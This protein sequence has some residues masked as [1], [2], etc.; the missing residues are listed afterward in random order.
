MSDSVSRLKELLFD[1]ERATLADLRRRIEIVA[2]AERK[3]GQEL[4]ERIRQ[5]GETAAKGRTELGARIE[6]VFERA[7]TE[8]RFRGS[9]A[10][11]LDGAL[12]EA[13]VQRHDE[14][15]RAIAPLVV[16]TIKTELANS[17]DDMVQ[18]LY[19]IT[20]RLVKAYVASAIKDLMDDINRKLEAGIAQNRLLL[21]LR[22][23]TTGRS[24]AELALA[25][26][27]KPAVT[28]A[29]LIK[30]G[31]GELVQRWP[32]SVVQSNTDI[33]LSGVLS[34]I[35]DFA[36]QAFKNDGGG[37]R[38]FEMDNAE[39]FLRAS[40]IY[41]LAVKV[42]GPELP[43]SETLMDEAFLTTM[44]RH[45]S[46]LAAPPSGAADA[47]TS[48]AVLE[49]LAHE[50]DAKLGE[51]HGRYANAGGGTKPLA[52]IAAALAV[53]L[54]ALTGWWLYGEIETARAR[55]A[56][57]QVVNSAASL[58]L[59]RP[60]V[61]V[62]RWGRTIT[63]T[64]LA[65]NEAVKSEVM[66]RLR[67]AL[68]G[69]QIEDRISV[70][71]NVLR[72]VEPQIATVRRDVN[73]LEGEITRATMARAVDRSLRRL[74]IAESD[75]ARLGSTADTEERRAIVREVRAALSQAIREIRLY[76]GV[77]AEARGDGGTLQQLS[78][79]LHAATR[80]LAEATIEMGGYLTGARPARTPSPATTA[81]SDPV[82]SAEDLAGAAER[83]ATRVLAVLEATQVRP[84]P[85]A[86]RVQE[87]SA[88]DRLAAFTKTDAVFF[89]NTV[90]YRTP[91]A[92]E[93]TLDKLKALMAETTTLVRVVG[94]TDE[95]GGTNRNTPL[96][97]SRA[98][99]V[100]A[101]LVARGVPGDRLVAVGR[102][103]GPDISPS[104]GVGSP[105][106]R[107]EFEIGFAGEAGSPR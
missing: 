35:N 10:T 66:D 37:V 86:V 38:S 30:R 51:R 63:V 59:Y 27:Q 75:L 100:V 29:F 39:V 53:P 89:A 57:N 43:G 106:R 67:Q 87:P 96:S 34:A 8:E 64:A 97:Q 49:T 76:Q 68:P 32:T 69:T 107:V 102:A 21:R 90:D 56:A 16:R 47:R 28:D 83:M 13:E 104:T 54:I 48:G 62:E 93:A 58:K 46:T 4:G 60:D 101:D 81:P 92:A 91:E 70:I 7:G 95:R 3:T 61:D 72:E 6:Q 85:V 1:G 80:R 98:D 45:R 94:Y 42:K 105:N 79:S 55:S 11:V 78:A 25:A 2:E 18:A 71:P 73:T 99:K 41:L 65:P 19:P 31:S 12:R 9:V 23:I 22:S 33:H 44:E 26:T 40:P 103:L 77:A 24:M 36:A 52:M 5:L 15:A 88:L 17:Q 82:R 20:G 74:E 14:L 50:L 84:A